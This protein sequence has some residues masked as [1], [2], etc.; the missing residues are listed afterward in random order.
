MDM[1]SRARRASRRIIIT[2]ALM[3]IAVV[4]T[5]IILALLVSGYWVGS[6]FKVERQGLLQLSSVPTG[7]NV[8]LDGESGWLQ[9]TNLSKVLSSGEHTI[10]LTKDG[11]D[12][13]SRTINIAEGL[14]Y[15]VQYPRLFLQNRTKE[16]VL[17]TPTAAFA[18]VAPARNVMLLANNTTTWTLLGIESDKLDEKP[19]VLPEDFPFTTRKVSSSATSS[20]NANRA[21]S[22]PD[23][24][25]TGTIV[26][27]EWAR[28]NEHLLL[29]LAEDGTTEWVL[30]NVKSPE[31]SINLTTTFRADFSTLRIADHS[32]S[33]L[34]AVIDGDLRRIDI[35]ARQLSA[36]LVPKV[37][38]FDY[39]DSTVI[40]SAASSASAG[41]SVAG[42]ST[43]S[44]TSPSSAGSADS[45][46]YEVG[47]L[48]LGGD[49]AT[50]LERTASPAKVAINKF[51]D[52][53][54][55]TVL[56]GTQLTVHKKTDYTDFLSHELSFSP[57]YLKVGRGGEFITAY[58]DGHLVATADMEARKVTEWQTS[59]TSF[60]WLDGSMVYSVLGG[61]LTVYDF[62]GENPRA[63]TTNVSS[64]FPVTISADKWLYYFSDGSLVR[65]KIVE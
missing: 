60:G 65:E 39:Y 15:R 33:S 2:E 9:R 24:F 12:S 35:S 40:Y 11:Y 49:S 57:D 45:D 27:A 23:G 32:G 53:E 34:L 44:A 14:L 61:A 41:S 3:V 47:L 63:L 42:A 6:G 5:V 55:L 43:D 10:V 19:V 18:T 58:R 59:D 8:E 31:N 26:S 56:T 52:D 30:M 7:A 29:Q 50:V 54:Y 36:V 25:F 4:I 46:R 38:D 51:Y 21:S 16:T 1:E 48:Q 20:T 37:Q 62:D 17:A 13:W 22:S 28:D 64:H